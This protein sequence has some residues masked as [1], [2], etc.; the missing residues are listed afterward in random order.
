M[1]MNGRRV[2]FAAQLSE[3]RTHASAAEL[4]YHPNVGDVG[5]RHSAHA[6]GER[7]NAKTVHICYAY[8]YVYIEI[9]LHTRR[10]RCDSLHGKRECGRGQKGERT[11]QDRKRVSAAL[12][13]C[14]IFMVYM[15]MNGE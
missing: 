6:T 3:Q 9:S 1:R 13:L 8:M 12:H 2:Q 11:N 10:L 15:R 14:I 7:Q 5:Y 4:Q